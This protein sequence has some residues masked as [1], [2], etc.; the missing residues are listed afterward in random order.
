MK[1]TSPRRSLLASLA[2]C[3]G[4]A[5][6]KS[7]MPIINNVLLETEAKGVR[8]AA[9]DLY[10][11]V[12]GTVE[13]QVARPGGVAVGARTLF[14]RVKAM[15]DGDVTVETDKTGVVVRAAGSK[16][17]FTC[18]SVPATEY[19]ALPEP[20][21]DA[22]RMAMPA[23]KLLGLIKRTEHAISD[24]HT[25]MHLHSALLEWIGP[26]LR[27]VATDWHRLSVAETKAPEGQRDNGLML[28]PKGGVLE[29]KRLLEESVK[30]GDGEIELI[31]QGF[32]L[33]VQADD[34][35]LGVKL[36]DAKFPP[37]EQ[38]VPKDSTTKLKIQTAVL[39]DAV[40][41]VAIS[42]DVT[43]QG[44]KLA[45]CDG[46]MRIQSESSESGSAFD[47]TEIDYS[48]PELVVGLRASYVVQALECADAEASLELSGELDPVVVRSDG[49]IATVMPMRC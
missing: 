8:I 34:V 35:R 6:K 42:A 2:R 21:S 11:S 22:T 39:I 49:Y 33:F 13:A 36:T 43:S 47:E 9:T 29:I 23:S 24:D 31:Q 3:L 10:L 5:D 26:V 12:T 17:R 16:R 20:A 19:P 32:Q 37:W 48:G 41:A 40:R 38:V 18:H 30:A 14:D 28:I 1:F 45:L 27:M 4:V 25:R 44:V 46:K 15:P 7:S